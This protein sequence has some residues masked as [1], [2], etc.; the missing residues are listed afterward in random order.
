MA[1][2]SSPA[3]DANH[4]V[5]LVENT[6]LDSVHDAPLETPIDVFLPRLRVEVGL[7]LREEE[8]IHAPVKVGVSC[9]TSVAGDHDDGAHR[10]ILG[11]KA[12]GGST[13]YH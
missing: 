7:G 5:A 13:S 12:G 9:S 8:W 1:H 3:L 4:G 10:A 2:S 6:E 11:D